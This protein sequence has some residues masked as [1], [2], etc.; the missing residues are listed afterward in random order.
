MPPFRFS[1]YENQTAPTLINLIRAG[2]QD[3]ARAVEAS[4]NAAANAALASGQ[5]HA[6]MAQA[7][8]TTLAN[9]VQAPLQ[10]RQIDLDQKK[11][12]LDT[13]LV[14][15]HTKELDDRD[16]I[17]KVLTATGNNPDAALKELEASGHQSAA[18]AFRGQVHAARMQGLQETD[19]Q[20]KVSSEKIK[21]AQSLLPT[22]PD[23]P[24]DEAAMQTFRANYAKAIPAIQQIVG[25]D[26][27]KTLPSPDDPNVADGVARLTDFGL[28]MSDRLAKRRAAIASA[29]L[30]VSKA[31]DAREADKY[32]TDSLGEYLSTV[33]S[34]EEWTKALENAKHLGASEQTLAKF[35]PT[36]SPEAVQRATALGPKKTA[37][38]A[39]SE[40][41]AIATWAREHNRS[42]DSLTLAEKE[43]I[44]AGH[45][46]STREPKDATATKAATL[47]QKAAAERWKQ[48]A[49][50]DLEKRFKAA[51]T[52]TPYMN[53][54]TSEMVV[55]PPM[56]DD[57]LAAE[58][59]RIQ[60]SYL[61]QIGASGTPA[62]KPN[63]A[64][65]PDLTGLK[66]GTARRFTEGPFKGQRWTL[67]PNGPT[68]VKDK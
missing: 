34:Q 7:V 60:A 8:G 28:S 35:D 47:A 50:D 14:G 9:L 26:I 57:D 12:A 29:Q 10:A 64:S 49:L 54:M 36:F 38:A 18:T 61:E 55:P 15:E 62:A 37:P 52:K 20:L 58:K 43:R 19:L 51:K 3:R 27:A 45:A 25:P 66:P 1:E 40:A 17:Q 44:R 6:Q 13:R 2:G 41:D 22:P 59:A 46:A 16:L 53:L 24:T 56:T 23:D 65:L 32:F 68:Q 39:G 5:A 67:G 63:A 48:G 11:A 33:D 42:V 31:K 30:A 4:G 21:Q